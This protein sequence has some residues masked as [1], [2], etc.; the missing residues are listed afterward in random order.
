MARSINDIYNNII[1]AKNAD[2]TLTSLQSVSA[3]ALF[4][5]WAY[6]FALASFTLETLFDQHKS[7]VETDLENLIPGTIRWYFN[8]CLLWQY[9]YNLNWVNNK[10]QYSVL[11]LTKQLIKFVSVSEQF[12]QLIIKVSKES[13]GIP[14]KLSTGELSS[15]IAYINSIKFA[16]TN[17][18]VISYDP[19]FILFDANIIYDPLVMNNDG[20]LISDGSTPIITALNVYLQGITYGGVFNKTKCID[21]LQNVTGVVDIWFNNVQAKAHNASNYNIISG[22]NYISVSGSYQL[23]TPLIFNFTPNV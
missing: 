5:L 1:A 2:T 4:K 22:Q 3:T 18:S 9:G 12:G 17:I 15:F 10:F 13:G 11:D 6:L 16:G 14:V 8:Q 19:D 20:T 7:E 23:Y 21:A